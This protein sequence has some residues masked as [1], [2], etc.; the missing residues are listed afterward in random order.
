MH[1]V[2]LFIGGISL[3]LGLSTP[4]S[5][6][7]QDSLMSNTI[8]IELSPQYPDP[9]DVVQATLND[10]SVNTA[11]SAISWSFDSIPQTEYANQRSLSFI[12]PPAGDSI[13]LTATITNQ[14]GQMLQARQTITPLYLD[15]IVEPQTYSPPFYKGRALPIF[16][17]QVFLTALL[18]DDSGPVDDSN[19]TYTWRIN[20]KTVDGGGARGGF[21]TQITIPHGQNQRIS[22]DVL[23]QQ[24]RLISRKTVLVPTAAVDIRF[25]ENH[26]LYGLSTKAITDGF[27]MLSNSTNIYAIPYNLA[28]SAFQQDLFTEWR[29]NNRQS[30]ASNNPFEITLSQQGTG[31]AKLA[32]KLRNRAEL[33]QGGENSVVVNF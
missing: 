33:L 26:P 7:L 23:D 27:T 3:F 4:V 12:A 24:N 18:Q 19:Y 29:I 28:N 13:V 11:G 9:G 31:T 30:T 10:Y 6:Q 32:F 8:S 21:R 1:I 22:V 16:G 14:S 5:A 25:Y 2:V 20:N 17:S 15:V